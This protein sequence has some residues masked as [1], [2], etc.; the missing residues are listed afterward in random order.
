MDA[1][2]SIVYLKPYADHIGA[3]LYIESLSCT[4]LGNAPEE[5]LEIICDI[6]GV[7]VCSNTN[8]YSKDSIEHFVKTLGRRI[9]TIYASDFNLVNESHWLPTQGKVDW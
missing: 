6:P 5:F 4:C 1:Q 9:G 2:R 8:R 3:Q 7:K